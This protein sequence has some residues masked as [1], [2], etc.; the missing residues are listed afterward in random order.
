MYKIL[1]TAAIMAVYSSAASA[2]TG[3]CAHRG[4]MKNAPENTVPAIRSAVAR[5]THQIEFDLQLSKDGHIVVIH[6]STVDR[7]T[8]GSGK[9]ADM[10]FEELR[11]LDAGSWFS[12]EYAGVQI[13]T[14]R[15]VLTEIPRR[16]WCNV[17]LKGGPD[18]GGAAARVLVAMDRLDRCF[19]A[20]TV[21]QA[22]AARAVAPD[23]KICNMSRQGGDRD[24][25]TNKTIKNNCDFIQ[26][27]GPITGL[28]PYVECLHKHGVTVNYFG[29]QTEPLI[30]RLAEVG[31]DYILTNDLDLCLDVLADYGTAPLKPD[32]PTGN[33]LADP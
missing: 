14:F 32:K 13:P 28:E 4:D 33:Q 22:Q 9:V 27:A 15:E 23:I 30:R 2:G 31:V 1:L 18:V 12:N 26:F 3:A 10:T 7:T 19:L 17:H 24:T 20:A 5:G 8:N 29:A 11:A 6:D 21:E 25:Y 16:I